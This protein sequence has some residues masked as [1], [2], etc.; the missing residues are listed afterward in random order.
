MRLERNTPGCKHYITEGERG[1]GPLGF[2]TR[3]NP[4]LLW[5][6]IRAAKQAGETSAARRAPQGQK[7]KGKHSVRR[8]Q[9]QR[10]V[11]GRVLHNLTYWCSIHIEERPGLDEGVKI[12]RG[13]ST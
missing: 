12:Q 6:I 4:R 7:V 2:N 3:C 10:D 8:S 11:Q 9:R 1:R 5:A 13:G